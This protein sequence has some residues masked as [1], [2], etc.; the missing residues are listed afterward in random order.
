M[1]DKRD[2]YEVM[3]AGKDKCAGDAALKMTRGFSTLASVIASL[4]LPGSARFLCIDAAGQVCYSKI[5]APRF[6]LF[7]ALRG[8]LVE[9]RV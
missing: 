7:G 9:R 6:D 4:W 5:T 2:Y 1:A 3:V 8:F